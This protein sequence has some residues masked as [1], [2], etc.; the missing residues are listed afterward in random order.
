MIQPMMSTDYEQKCLNLL[1]VGLV[2]NAQVFATL[3]L[4][5]AIREAK[6]N[7]KSNS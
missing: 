4:A 2:Q 1:D 7:G 6:K 3:S 5:A